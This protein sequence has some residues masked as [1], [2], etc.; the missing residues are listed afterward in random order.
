M[1]VESSIFM[2]GIA[3]MDMN[4][5]FPQFLKTMGASALLIGIIQGLRQFMFFVPYPYVIGMIRGKPLVKGYL[6]KA[7]LWGRTPLLMAAGVLWL[8]PD[9]HTLAIVAGTLAIIMFTFGDG[10]GC[11]PWYELVGRL[12]PSRSRGRFFGGMQTLGALSALA[13]SLVV[14]KIMRL[15]QLNET[16]RY[17]LL[18][19]CMG[20]LLALS[21]YLITVIR[22]GYQHFSEDDND[23]PQGFMEQI[24]HVPVCWKRDQSLRRLIYT[25][26]LITGEGLSMSFY[27][28]Y[29]IDKYHLPADWMAYFVTAGA[30]GAVV[31]GPL[32]GLVADRLGAVKS[33]KMMVPLAVIAPAIAL[34]SWSPVAFLIVFASI[35]SVVFGVWACMTNTALAIAPKIDRPTYIAL[36]QL[37]NFPLSITPIIG[38]WV[39]QNHGYIP[40]FILTLICVTAGAVLAQ[41]IPKQAA[42]A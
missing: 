5:L 34:V 2:M 1:V 7:C 28:L 38:G 25:Q 27:G 26:L 33:L 21:T 10:F 12:I 11:L 13:A 18:F 14:P 30:A 8:Q 6:L 4:T 40:V 22:E 20:L 39:I 15:T 23:Q 31:T 36:Q 32:W 24:R 29:A 3:F 9:N 37:A 42:L 16:H 41:R 19:G 35:G 17:A